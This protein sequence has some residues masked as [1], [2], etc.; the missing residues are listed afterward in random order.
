MST[1][2]ILQDI[3]TEM[4][5]AQADMLHCFEKNI[6]PSVSAV[7]SFSLTVEHARYALRQLRIRD[8][9]MIGALTLIAMPARPDGTYNRDR[10]ACEELVRCALKKL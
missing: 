10:R 3:M 9:H 8:G 5:N 2:N 4:Q 7:N 6:V 1:M